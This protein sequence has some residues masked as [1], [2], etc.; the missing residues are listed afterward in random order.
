M[1]LTKNAHIKLIVKGWE[2]IEQH[3]DWQRLKKGFITV[4]LMVFNQTIN[5][6]ILD[7]IKA[8]NITLRELDALDKL[9][10]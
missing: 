6:T 7:K 1:K 2:S 5:A 3:K 10:N 9:L 8:K 4:D